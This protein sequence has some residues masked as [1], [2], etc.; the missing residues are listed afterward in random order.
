MEQCVWRAAY[1]SGKAAAVLFFLV[2]NGMINPVTNTAKERGN[3]LKSLIIA[4]KPSVAAD[5]ARVLGVRQRR[6]GYIEGDPYVITW[7]VGH[8]INLKEPE[9]YDPRYKKW[10]YADL[11]ILPREM[12]LKPYPQT[13]AQLNIL[14]TLAERADVGE[15]ICATDSG[16]EG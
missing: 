9:D 13:E 4:E 16:R 11:P 7:A 14:R 6:N 1:V 15:L 3:G 12:G 10:Q 2:K 8:L 5:I